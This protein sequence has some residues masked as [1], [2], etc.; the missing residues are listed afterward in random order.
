MTRRIERIGKGIGS[1]G[2]GSWGGRALFQKKV[3]KANH[4]SNGEVAIKLL[5]IIKRKN[6]ELK[7][8][9]EIFL[10][11]DQKILALFE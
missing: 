7:K 5:S 2:G 1:V 10:V 8:L 6:E 11:G 3:L 4:F 9:M